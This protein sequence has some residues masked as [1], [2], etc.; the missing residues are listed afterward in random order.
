MI[1]ILPFEKDW[2]GAHGVE[3]VEYVG[4][5]LANDVHATKTKK[6][7]CLDHGLDPSRP[8]VSLLPGSRQKEITRVLPELLAAA[9][10]LCIKVRGIQFVIALS[11]DRHRQVV[12]DTINVSGIEARVISGE[13]YN[14]LAASDAAAVTSGTATLEA[15]IL[16]TPMVIV[17]KTSAVNY[18]LLEP[19]IDVPHY[20]LINL[21]AGERLATELIQTDLTPEKLS[22]ELERLLDPD[23]NA[24]MRERLA[25]TAAKLGKGGASKRAAALILGLVKS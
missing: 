13:T 10:L 25:E 6:V 24:K 17:Y 16:G 7:F 2:Y 19:M 21:I 20:G 5:P 22:A 11:S 12:A 15:G 9:K 14:A 18:K 4:N 3:H 23:T 8:M 1:T